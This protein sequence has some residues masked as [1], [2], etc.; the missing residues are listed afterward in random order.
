MNSFYE[1]NIYPNTKTK[2]TTRK[3]KLQANIP[4]EYRCRNSQQ[5]ISKPNSTI[6]NQDHIP[7]SNGIYS[8]FVSSV[9]F[10]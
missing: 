9:Q 1:A 2:D 3:W 10:P 8:R 6:H 7:W 5:N 4:D